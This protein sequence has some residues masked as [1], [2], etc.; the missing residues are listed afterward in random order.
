M[1]KNYENFF[2]LNITV[3]VTT[4]IA[5]LLWYIITDQY[6]Q[7]NYNFLT[8]TASVFYTSI[9]LFWRKKKPKT[10]YSPSGETC[11]QAISSSLLF[12]TLIS[13]IRVKH[14]EYQIEFFEVVL[15]ICR[16]L[17][18]LRYPKARFVILV[19]KT[20]RLGPHKKNILSRNFEERSYYYELIISRNSVKM[21]Q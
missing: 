7:I 8:I 2:L 5:H 1:T 15:G 19:R 4:R 16:Q 18:Q 10:F 17:L 20:N 3:L 11:S 12:K 13:K 9:A 14:V 21:Y 6:V